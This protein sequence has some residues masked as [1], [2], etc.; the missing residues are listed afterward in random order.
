MNSLDPEIFDVIILPPCLCTIIPRSII[1]DRF[2]CC[3]DADILA[4]GIKKINQSI[5]NQISQSPDVSTYANHVTRLFV[6]VI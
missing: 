5:I 6:Y 4:S 2:L 1:R 3:F